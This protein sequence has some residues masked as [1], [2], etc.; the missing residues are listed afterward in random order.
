MNYPGYNLKKQIVKT[1][2]LIRAIPVFSAILICCTFQVTGQSNR[3]DSLIYGKN[4]TVINGTIPTY[5]SMSCKE[6]ANESHLLLQD[7]SKMY[8]SNGNNEFKLKLAVIDSTDWTGFAVPY[9]FG[10]ISQG[11]I[12][13]PGDL[14]FDKLSHLWGYYKFRDVMKINI[15][16]ISKDPE[17]QLIDAIYKF[18]P[19]NE[20]GHYYISNI[21]GARNPDKWTNEL[22]ASYFTMDFL[23]KIDKKAEKTINIFSST[24]AKEYQPAY[25][26][27]IDFNTKY[28]AVGLENYIWYSQ[29]FILMGEEIHSKY[30]SDFIK[31]YAKTFPKTPDPKKFPQEEL[32]K[33]MNDL[34]G[35]ITSKW[36]KIME[37]NS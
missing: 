10:F 14:N 8:S 11:W 17:K 20:L 2:I 6:R 13:I 16:K 15:K 12:I 21:L 33:I 26:T 24:Y 7:I 36:I 25:R 23:S 3:M 37:G 30:K 22:M 18:F 5:Y 29:M 34:T 9:G 35:V 31:S 32:L 4:L 28:A 27:L 1:K 19:V